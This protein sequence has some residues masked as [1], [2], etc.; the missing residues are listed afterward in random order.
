LERLWPDYDPG[1]AGQSL[2]SLTYQLNKLTT[3]ILNGNDLIVR[4]NG[5][6]R[7]NT[8]EGVG[9]DVDYFDAWYEAGQQLLGQGD[10]VSA[11][12]YYQKALSLYHSNLCGDSS[13]ATVMERERLRI[14]FLNLLAHLA[15]HAYHQNDYQQ[16][17]HYI[18]RLLGHEPCRE[19]AHRQAMRCYVR[20]DQRA[21]A[22][23]QY[24]LCCQALA[25]EFDAQPEPATIALYDQIRLDPVSV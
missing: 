4:D 25:S 15:D 21:Q 19:D 22:L 8:G 23:R 11:V 13:L 16:A 1:L 7:L 6:Y 12:A 5:Y 10:V 14:A 3:K 17:L 20:L 24:R 9:I 2:N 18:Q